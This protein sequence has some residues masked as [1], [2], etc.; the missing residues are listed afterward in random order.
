MATADSKDSYSH[1]LKYT[2]L[3][4]GVQ[5]LNILISLVRTKIVA[6]LLGPVGMG[7]TA[8]F[9]SVVN[10]VSQATNLGISFSAVRNISEIFESGDEERI[11]H[12][13]KIVRGWS[14]LAALIGMLVCVSIGPLLSLY[15]FSYGNHTLH[16]VLLAPIVGMTAITGGETAILKGSR[17]LKALAVIQV[18]TVLLALLISAPI[19]Y[20][21]GI[22]GIIPVLLLIA[23]VTMLFTVVYSYRYYPLR[24]RGAAGVLGEGVGM[25]RIGVAFVLGSVF[26]AGADLLIRSFLSVQEGLDV[27]GLYNAGYMITV[28]YAGMVFSAMETDYFP[29]LS[30]VHN[31]SKEMN[32]LVNRQ[33]EVSVVI[34]SPMLVAMIVLLPF[35]V[36][37]LLASTFN[38]VVPMAQVTVISMFF[39]A[40]T[41]PVA[42]INLAKGNSKAFLVLEALY[43]VVLVVL[44]LFGFDRWGLYGTGVAIIVAHIIDWFAIYVYARIKYGYEIS[45][46]AVRY[47]AVQL[48]LGLITYAV[49]LMDDIDVSTLFGIVLCLLSAAFSLFVLNKKTSLFHHR[50]HE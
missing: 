20:F 1:I 6:V 31:D 40:A 45:G 9:N 11:A 17:R 4:G 14:I 42:Y 7:L 46:S 30:A 10:F 13:I 36:P 3:F 2:S 35:I 24:L 48:P 27:V 16:F 12:T 8:L 47:L 21:F 49:T 33:I 39:K 23:L 32:V 22:A 50:R 25:V 28:T 26:G 18:W 5:G 44:V 38:A 29:R 41:L 34:V 19:Y 43:A 37:V 15:S